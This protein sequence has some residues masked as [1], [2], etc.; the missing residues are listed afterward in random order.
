MIPKPALVTSLLLVVAVLTFAGVAYQQVPMSTTQSSIE[1]E[2]SYSPYIVTD[3]VTYT[4]TTIESTSTYESAYPANTPLNNYYNCF[5]GGG[6]WPCVWATETV[7]TYI[8]GTA[9]VQSEY[10]V[11]YTAAIPYSQTVTESSTSLVPASD[12]IGLTDGS[13][14]AVAVLVIGNLAVLTAYL[15]LKLGITHETKKR[16]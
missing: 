8:Y 16:R 15:V 10:Q 5:P 12:A 11:Q 9:T 14:A 4:A 3:T 2:A 13:F 7:T 1:T 6:P